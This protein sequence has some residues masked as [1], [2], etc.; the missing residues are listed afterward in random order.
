MLKGHRIVRNDFCNNRSCVA[1]TVKG[2]EN[3]IIRS[4]CNKGLQRHREQY[5]DGYWVAVKGTESGI[6]RDS[7]W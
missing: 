5:N 1:E 6:T 4:V 3:G 7:V 2:T